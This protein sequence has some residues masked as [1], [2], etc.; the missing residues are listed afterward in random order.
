MPTTA[1]GGKNGPSSRVNRRKKHIQHDKNACK[2]LDV[3]KRY[4]GNLKVLRA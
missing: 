3:V 1:R 4:F 2:N